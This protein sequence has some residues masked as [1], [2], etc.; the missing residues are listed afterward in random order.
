MMMN[1]N[2]IV[3][4][5][6][7]PLIILSILCGSITLPFVLLPIY[8]IF[9]RY[10]AIKYANI[11]PLATIGFVLTLIAIGVLF[12]CFFPSFT[13]T[14]QEQGIQRFW[15]IKILSFELYKSDIFID[16]NQIINFDY[17]SPG[18]FWWGFIA[19]GFRKNGKD[20]FIGFNPLYKNYKQ[21]VLLIASKIDQ[22]KI[23]DKAKI[24]LELVGK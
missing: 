13:L 3:K 20:F 4:Y 22:N 18:F 2:I 8:D 21:A 1:K 24:K 17:W 5:K 11:P 16:W 23:T 7:W 12:F 6:A 9:F 14:I 19:Q 10:N 15:N